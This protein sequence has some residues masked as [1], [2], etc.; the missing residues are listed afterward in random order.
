MSGNNHFHSFN[1]SKQS[2]NCCTF[3]GNNVKAENGDLKD[4]QR[5]SIT[6]QNNIFFTSGI[7]DLRTEESEQ[8]DNTTDKEGLNAS[9]G[10]GLGISGIRYIFD[11]EIPSVRR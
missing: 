1:S 5:N 7:T 6:S 10:E 2:C 8:I 11:R 3:R 9:L 4:K